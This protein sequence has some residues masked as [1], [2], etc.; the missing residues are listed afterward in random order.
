M[1]HSL[2]VDI[3]LL[4]RFTSAKRHDSVSFLV[5]FHEFEKHMPDLHISNMCLDSAMDNYPTYKRTLSPI[6]FV[7]ALIQEGCLPCLF[8]TAALLNIISSAR[9]PLYY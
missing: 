8:F 3:P 7:S 1:R 2:H 5:A 9:K 4:L 6:A